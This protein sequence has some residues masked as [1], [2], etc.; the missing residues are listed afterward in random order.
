MDKGANA[1]TAWPIEAAAAGDEKAFVEISRLMGPLV[2]SMIRSFSHPGVEAEDLAQESLLGLLAAIRTYRPQAGAAFTTYACACI[3]NR[4]V[5]LLRRE[6]EHGVLRQPLEEDIQASEPSEDDPAVRLQAQ[7][8]FRRLHAQMQQRLTPLEYQVL[9]ARLDHR[10]YREIAA[11]LG[12]SEKAID[13]AVQRLRR[14]M[15]RE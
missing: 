15:S 13:N 7:E 8:A 1:S 3:R 5:S 6:E 10:S 9:L 14:K 4:L 2:Q 12:V 11:T